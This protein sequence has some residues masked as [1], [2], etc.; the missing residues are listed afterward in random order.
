MKS[1]VAIVNS[2][3]FGKYFPE[4]VEI[5]QQ[6]FDVQRFDLPPKLSGR[7]LADVLKGFKYIIASTTPFFDSVFFD[8]VEGLVLISRHG[9]GY[10]NIDIGKATEKGVIVTKVRGGAEREAVAEHAIALCMS[11]LRKVPQSYSKVLQSK[12]SERQKFFGI[13]LKGKT[14]GII[15]FGNIGS[16]VA[17][18][19]HFGFNADVV[20]YDPFVAEENMSYVNARKVELNELVKLSDVIFICAKYTKE[21]YHI[22][23]TN[24]F[25]MMK[26][27]VYI[28]NT[29]RGELIDQEALIQALESGKV[30]GVGLDVVEGEPINGEHPLLRFDNVV[31][32]PHIAA[33]TFESIRAMGDKVVSDVLRAEERIIPE[34]VVNVAVIK[35]LEEEGWKRI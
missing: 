17:E 14:V 22:L 9:L 8:N 1:K 13:E 10:D 24:E 35:K 26:E 18:I 20:V 19:V 21:N 28:V 34:E 33:Y 3:S 15:G 32:T 12:W 5:L 29:S 16:R 23:S 31:V 2:S 11:V 7:E 6:K 25:E 30:A 4:H 27:G